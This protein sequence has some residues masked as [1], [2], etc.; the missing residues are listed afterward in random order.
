ML[1]ICAGVLA[2]FVVGSLLMIGFFF[3]HASAFF[4]IVGS[5]SLLLGFINLLPVK[6]NSLNVDSDATRFIGMI[7]FSRDVG[8]V[9]RGHDH[10]GL[11]CLT[12]KSK[13]NV[14]EIPAEIE[15]VNDDKTPMGYV[16]CV[17]KA[18]FK[19]DEYAAAMLMMA[20]HQNGK[21]K[22]GWAD[23]DA[24]MECVNSINQKSREAAYPF[25]CSVSVSK[26]G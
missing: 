26:S 24:A 4:A 1:I 2:N 17:L 15:F 19:M 7:R 13:H 18:C 6:T 12:L 9:V 3:F 10:S 22:I 16:V 20:I 21:A 14:V 23:F 25:S 8:S 11:V 5:I